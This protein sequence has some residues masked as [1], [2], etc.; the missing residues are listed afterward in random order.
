MF[1]PC[2]VLAIAAA[3]LSSLPGCRLAIFGPDIEHESFSL[4]GFTAI[5]GSDSIMGTWVGVTDYSENK[6][7]YEVEGSQ[8]RIIQINSDG[9]GG[10]QT[11]DCQGAVSK[12]NLESTSIELLGRKLSLDSFNEISGIVTTYGDQVYDPYGRNEKWAWLKISNEDTG[13]GQVNIDVI[14]DQ[15]FSYEQR[16]L[17]FCLH[18]YV[19]IEYEDSEQDLSD[20]VRVAWDDDSATDEYLSA[21]DRGS[22]GEGEFIAE[23]YKWKLLNIPGSGIFMSSHRAYG[24]RATVNFSNNNNLPKAYTATFEADGPSRTSENYVIKVNLS[25]I[26]PE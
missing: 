14:S 26:I 13:L 12:V 21:V 10:Y 3:L 16:V 6:L 5:E 25:F 9:A 15:S 24:N 7:H 2:L 23:S 19:Y 8:L 11:Y 17:A 22:F 4:S 1:K 18:S 20:T